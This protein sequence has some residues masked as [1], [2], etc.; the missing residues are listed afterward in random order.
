MAPG[1]NIVSR[2]LGSGTTVWAASEYVDALVE[3]GIASPSIFINSHATSIIDDVTRSK[4]TSVSVN[5]GGR[6]FRIA[7]KEYLP[8]GG[9]SFLKNLFR[10]SKARVELMLSARLASL[11]VLVPQPV[12]AVEV[13]IWRVLRKSYLFAEEIVNGASMLEL[14]DRQ[15]H[16]A[17]SR[18]RKNT[19]IE[20]IGKAVAHAHGAGL[21][22]GDLNASHILIKDFKEGE[23]KVY[24]V[25]FEN[26]RIR[27]TVSKAECLRDIGRLERS[28]SY[29]LP[30]TERL[31][32][33]RSY[34]Q[35]AGQD[36]P[37][38]DWARN[39]ILDIARRAR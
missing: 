29:F 36:A 31:R 35:T 34:L 23:V 39:V 37:L 17:L 21:F 2:R 11:G 7:A 13:R 19:V 3:S 15:A 12:A 6:A 38:R 1:F 33:L 26:S 10:P 8:R 9:A 20:A 14:L 22:H 25:D 32:F 30:V 4:I 24:L 5:L 27:K 18:Q 28:A 16:V